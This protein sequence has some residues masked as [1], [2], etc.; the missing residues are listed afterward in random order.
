M[1]TSIQFFFKG[2]IMAEIDFDNSF[3]AVNWLKSQLKHYSKL[4]IDKNRL[5]RIYNVMV[6][7][8]NIADMEYKEKGSYSVDHD[9]NI[10]RILVLLAKGIIPNDDNFGYL[11]SSNSYLV[12]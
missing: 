8:E 5:D 10:K 12:K 1:K 2:S 6:D 9:N 3:N 4:K 11:I 7:I